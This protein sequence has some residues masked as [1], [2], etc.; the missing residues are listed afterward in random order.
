MAST[1]MAQA[2]QLQDFRSG[3]SFTEAI[4][5]ALSGN[6]SVLLARTQEEAA[7]G[8]EQAAR[9]IFEFNLN[10]QSGSSRANDPLKQSDRNS[11]LLN[12]FDLR[13]N[14]S[15]TATTQVGASKLFANGYQA[16]LVATHTTSMSNLFP[17]S[18][19]PRQSIG[20]LTFQLR[21]PILRNSGRVTAAPLR[22]AEL[23]TLAA[24]GDLE[25][26]VSNIVLSSALAYWDY[27]A[28][29]QR[30][31][32]AR[33]SER[34][35]EE[36]LDELRKLIAADELPQ[37]EINLGIASQNDRRVARISAEQALL[38]SRRTLGRALGFSAEATMAIGQLKDGFPEYSDAI[39]DSASHNQETIA[40]SLEMR[41]DL[42]ALRHRLEAAQILFDAAR[43]N[44]LPQLDLVLGMTQSGLAEG[45]SS[46]DFGPAFRQNFGQGY[47]GN[48]IFQM[49]LGNN[50]ARGLIR[51]QAA[52]VDAQRIRI[53]EL[54]HAISGNIET[55]AY[56]TVRSGEQLKQ[57]DAAVKTYAIGLANERTKRSL[58]L[59]TL[60]DIL[61]VEDRYNNALLSAVQSRQAYAS[62]IAQFRFEAGT[63]ISREGD[64]YIARITELLTPSAS[65][66]R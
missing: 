5:A 62:A 58:G 43:K 65:V 24:R 45:K 6:S 18:S 52:L 37:A 17:A 40:R 38:E 1:K 44:E 48:L 31:T 56:A 8:A 41:S 39:T 64:S 60:I 2:Q 42:I 15:D 36:S 20:A 34:R 22:S 28:K 26:A 30:L 47:S 49:P 33:N 11:L 4:S 32:I 14:L 53:N 51:Q 63:L 61:S 13:Y 54:G 35:G 23:E 66:A 57:A 27:L 16:N 7:Q 9:G 25:F 3:L 46:A 10:A 19:T 12:G 55:A 21:V 59:S 29:T 50:A